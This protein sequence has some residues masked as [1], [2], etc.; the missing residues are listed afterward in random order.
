MEMSFKYSNKE[1]VYDVTICVSDV[2]ASLQ[3]HLSISDSTNGLLALL[4][5]SLS[6]CGVFKQFSNNSLVLSIADGELK[7]K[8]TCTCSLNTQ[9]YV[10][11]LFTTLTTLI[12]HTKKPALWRNYALIMAHS[13]QYM[14]TQ[15]ICELKVSPNINPIHRRENI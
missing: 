14:E 8:L 13:Q 6:Y 9:P 5:N 11:S 7:G 12:I 4:A 3:P 10:I 1:L 15:T 2:K